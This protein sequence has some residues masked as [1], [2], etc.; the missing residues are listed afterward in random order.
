MIVMKEHD[1]LK[2]NM[3]K[4]GDWLMTGM[5][6]GDWLKRRILTVKEV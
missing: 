6:G 3:Q 5:E 2:E 1:W 4:C